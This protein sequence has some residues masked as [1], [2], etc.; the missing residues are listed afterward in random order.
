MHGE[1]LPCPDH[2]KSLGLVIWATQNRPPQVTGCH[3]MNG[4]LAQ[5]GWKSRRA[6]GAMHSAIATPR[7]AVPL[8]TV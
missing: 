3:R 6:S 2:Q 8:G 4:L 7:M 1:V 5:R